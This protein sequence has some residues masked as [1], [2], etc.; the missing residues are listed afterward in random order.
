MESDFEVEFPGY[1]DGYEFETES[2]GYL[3]DVVVRRGVRQWNLTIYDS[4]RLHQEV[5]D[6]IERSG[7]CALSH[8][9]VVPSVTRENVM[10]ALSDLANADFEDLA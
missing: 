10:S 6:E 5:L 8:V 7:R 1:L 9:L 2:K 4:A 3:V